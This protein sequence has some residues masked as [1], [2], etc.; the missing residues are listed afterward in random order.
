VEPSFP[1]LVLI[2]SLSQ[3]DKKRRAVEF[4]LHE[5]ELA[6]AREKLDRVDQVKHL[7]HR[8]LVMESSERSGVEWRAALAQ[9]VPIRS[10]SAQRALCLVR[11]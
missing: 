1:S 11:S 6:A 9:T 8:Y 4:A 2:S 5:K 7:H 3:V 10:G